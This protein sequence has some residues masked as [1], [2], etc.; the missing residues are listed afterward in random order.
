LSRH[1]ERIDTAA[2]GRATVGQRSAIDGNET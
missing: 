2:T 1:P